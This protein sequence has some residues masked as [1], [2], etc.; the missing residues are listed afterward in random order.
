MASGAARAG[1]GDPPKRINK[2]QTITKPIIAVAAAF[3]GRG[4]V[5]R[6]FIVLSSLGLLPNYFIRTNPSFV[7]Y[8]KPML[9]ISQ[10]A[11]QSIG[12]SSQFI[13]LIIRNSYMSQRTQNVLK[14][15]LTAATS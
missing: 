8:K 14:P 12:V 3:S 9:I 10:T 13:A 11:L 5:R 7:R 6:V 1:Q 4:I 15:I 2:P